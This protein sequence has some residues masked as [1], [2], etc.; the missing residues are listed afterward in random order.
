M[1]GWKIREITK[2]K[3][4]N[5]NSAI[6]EH[7][8][9]SMSNPQYK[10]AGYMLHNHYVTMISRICHALYCR[11]GFQKNT[12][13]DSTSENFLHYLLKLQAIIL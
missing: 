1:W 2:K 12:V 8:L 5:L 6:I 10:S 4:T 11:E 3:N 9:N 7:N 13:S